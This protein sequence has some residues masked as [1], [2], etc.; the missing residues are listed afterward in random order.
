[1]DL[2]SAISENVVPVG[3]LIALVLYGRLGLKAGTLRSLQAQLALFGV[4]W[5]AA[6]LPRALIVLRVIEAT[7]DAILLGLFLHTVS[8]IIFGGLI[9]LRFNRLRARTQT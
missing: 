1:M 6:E 9:V 5:I 8:M 2:I 7:P 3:L 4:V